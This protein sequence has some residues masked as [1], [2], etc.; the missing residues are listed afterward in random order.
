MS[1]LRAEAELA[2]LLV[3]ELFLAMAEQSDAG[4][5]EARTREAVDEYGEL[6]GCAV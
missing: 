3:F 2:K 4:D 6:A 1:V 5:E